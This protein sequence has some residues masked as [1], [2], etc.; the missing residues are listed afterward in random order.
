MS[1]AISRRRILTLLGS[2]GATVAMAACGAAATPTPA[3]KPVEAP[4]PAAPAPKPAEAAKPAPTK[5][6]EAAKPA[7]AAPATKAGV[8]FE[9]ATRVGSDAE[10]MQKTVEKFNAKTGNKAKHVAYP[11]E[12]EY[13]AKVLA[14]HAT[15]QAADVIWSSVCCLHGFAAKGVL[16][17]LEPLILGDKYNIEDY[18][19]AGLD[20]MKLNGKLY[21]MPWGG[22]PGNGGILYNVDLLTKAGLNVT[23]DASSFSNVTWDQIVDAGKKARSGDVFGFSMGGDMLSFT[24]VTG[25]YGGEFLSADGKKLTIDTPEFRKGLQ[26]I[27]D[28]HNTHKIAP[29]PD[30]K[31]NT[32]ELFATGK[33]A[34]VQTGYWGQFSPGPKAIADK[35]KWNVGLTPK[36][37]AGKRGT[38]LTINGQTVWSGTKN[39]DTAWE[40]V[41]FLMDPEQNVE[42]VLA[43]GGRPALRKAVLYNERLMKENRAHKV[44][45]ESIEAAEPWKQPANLRWTEFNAAI[46]Q[47][48]DNLRLGKETVDEAIKNATPRLQDIIDKPM[49]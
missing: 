5:P 10:V 30:P 48:F 7:G 1:S 34:M 20:S 49:L 18:V 46:V 16:A 17:E 28:V 31:L 8:E 19:K 40:F 42:I 37:P 23:E 47:N 12:P 24:N 14:V 25:S 36:G 3:P 38:A 41:K 2:A 44:F 9:V 11:G 22:H 32:G 29:T 21:G 35:F 39:R 27:Y 43:G 13:F 15:K 33:L 45:V 26:W 6:A 4:K